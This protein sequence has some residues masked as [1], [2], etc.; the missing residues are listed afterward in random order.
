M[1]AQKLEESELLYMQ[2]T[3]EDQIRREKL[4]YKIEVK[5]S[6]VA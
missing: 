5:L 2:V 3:L 6:K 4:P 1:I